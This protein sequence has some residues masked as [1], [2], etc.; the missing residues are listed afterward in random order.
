MNKSVFL[1]THL[2]HATVHNSTQF[3]PT[4][5]DLFMQH[6]TPYVSVYLSTSIYLLVFLSVYLSFCLLVSVYLYSFVFLS[7]RMFIINC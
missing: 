7:G 3:E 4:K 6:D 5:W 1:E 2:L